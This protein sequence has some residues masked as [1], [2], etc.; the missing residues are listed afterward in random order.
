MGRSRILAVLAAATIPILLTAWVELQ[1]VDQPSAVDPG[2]TF[3]ATVSAVAHV[4]GGPIPLDTTIPSPIPR[5]ESTTLRLG[6]LVP[7]D[8]EVSGIEWAAGSASGSLASSPDE[9]GVYGIY[10]PPPNGYAWRSFLG[11]PLSVSEGELV[12]YHADITVGSRTGLYRVVYMTWS[13]PPYLDGGGTGG[14]DPPSSPVPPVDI[15]TYPFPGP[16]LL[17]HYRG[18]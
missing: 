17:D 4:N 8:W 9:T 1:S 2:Q 11:K 7:T 16:S 3:T 5:D 6:V 18:G 14:V 15:Y 10:Y 13:Q 12:S